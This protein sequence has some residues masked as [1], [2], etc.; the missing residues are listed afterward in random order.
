MQTFVGTPSTS[1]VVICPIGVTNSTK[2]HSSSIGVSA[3]VEEPNRIVFGEQLPGH[4]ATVVSVVGAGVVVTGKVVVLAVVEAVVVTVV[5]VDV[6]VAFAVVVVVR[7]GHAVLIVPDTVKLKRVK[8]P[9][10]SQLQTAGPPHVQVSKLVVQLADGQ[11]APGRVRHPRNGMH[12]PVGTSVLQNGF[13]G[14]KPRNEGHEALQ[15][16]V[17]VAVGAGVVL[18]VGRVV[19]LAVVEAVVVVVT[20][21]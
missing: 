4:G 11:M 16:P 6:V 8:L 7:D 21:F 9:V 15:A 5:D 13:T 1:F 17:V 20:Q 2:L 19:V 18:V 12:T 14:A 10:Y 3:A